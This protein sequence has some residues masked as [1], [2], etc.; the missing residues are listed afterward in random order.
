MRIYFNNTKIVRSLARKLAAEVHAWGDELKLSHAQTM[1]ARSFGYAD[2][3]ELHKTCGLGDP[4]AP[5]K[6]VSSDEQTF[7]FAQ[8]A[9]ILSDNDFSRDEATT[10]ITKLSSG[11]WWGFGQQAV[12]NVVEQEIARSPIKMQF[13]DI[14][15]V[16]R[17]FGTFHRALK[18]SGVTTPIGARKLMAKVFGHDTYSD[19]LECA[20]H[21][22]PT[23]SDFYISPKELDER[24][25]AYLRV[26]K[27]AG[28]SDDQANSVLHSA[29]AEG[30]WQLKRVQRKGDPRQEDFADR[31]EGTGKPTWRPNG[32]VNSAL[33][34]LPSRPIQ[35][36]YVMLEFD[37]PYDEAHLFAVL[38][39]GEKILGYC[40][41]VFG[42]FL[43]KVNYDLRA[44]V[45]SIY[46][47]ILTMPDTRAEFLIL[48]EARKQRV[49]GLNFLSNKYQGS[50][51]NYAGFVQQGGKQL[52]QAAIQG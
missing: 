19:F 32:S 11:P 41:D 39:N 25:E 45:A 20:G 30:W 51:E 17:F 37:D 15:A 23:P 34:R 10:L 49:S 16:A 48:R 7:R 44:E 18:E 46:R 42:A 47:E 5:D 26:L 2:Y 38:R 8:Y 4:S 14:A 29:G 12:A 40:D 3:A 31:I 27:D 50:F 1:V 24:I 33:H 22:V 43:D 52:F 28:L 35:Y 6:I 9:N 36:A 13:R 21:G